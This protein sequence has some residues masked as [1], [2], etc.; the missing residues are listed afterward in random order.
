MEKLEIFYKPYGL[1]GYHKYFVYTTNSG[2]RLT[3]RSGPDESGPLPSKKD[4]VM[5]LEKGINPYGRLHAISGVYQPG[6]IDYPP[7]GTFHN[8][9]VITRGEDLSLLWVQL[10]Q[11]MDELNH[12][13]HQYH[14]TL[15]SSNTVADHV[16][17]KL[18]LPLPKL[19]GWGQ[20]WAPG[21]RLPLKPGKVEGT[22][23]SKT[24]PQ[25]CLNTLRDRALATLK[26]NP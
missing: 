3:C 2:E 15:Q 24:V 6:W 23:L 8:S 1:V 25:E 5:T 17:A 9:E 22:P 26:Q 7:T 13:E 21:S 20:W 4:A 10:K 14:P 16:L 12:V 11:E 19:D 18:E